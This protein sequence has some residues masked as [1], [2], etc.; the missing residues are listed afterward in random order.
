MAVTRLWSETP[1]I[2]AGDT[3]TVDLLITPVKRLT[4][5]HAF[6]VVS[7]TAEQADVPALTEQGSIAGGSFLSA[8]W[9]WLLL[10]G[11]LFIVVLVVMLGMTLAGR[12]P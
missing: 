8:V 4:T 5:M 3:V 11:G 9:P 10:V 6:T 2:K 12:F 1:Y 7:K